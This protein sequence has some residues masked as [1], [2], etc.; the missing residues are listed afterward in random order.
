MQNQNLCKKCLHWKSYNADQTV[1]G[2]CL[3][4]KKQEMIR[5]CG[6]YLQ[7]H[8]NFGC[9]SFVQKAESPAQVTET[10]NTE[11]KKYGNNALNS[12]ND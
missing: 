7:T 12:I 8:A 4:L 10:I 1:W 6:T 5:T 11:K 2:N 3:Q 9:N